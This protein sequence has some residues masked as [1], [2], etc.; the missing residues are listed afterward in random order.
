MRIHHR[1]EGPTD[2]P[3]L[4]LSS[5]L[6]TDL[7]LWSRNTPHWADSYRLLRYDHR[8]HGGSELPPGAFGVEDLGRDLLR[9][10]DRLGIERASFCGLSL[11]GA[12]GQWLAVNEPGRVDRLVLACTAARF[13]EPEGWLERAQTVRADGLGAIADAVVGRWFTPA[14]VEREPELVDVFR[15]R[16]LAMSAAAYAAACEALAEWD[17]RERVAAIRTPTLVIA[18]ADDPSRPPAD[19][20]LLADR[21]PDARLVILQRAAHLANVEQPDAFAA[22]VS[23]HLALQEAA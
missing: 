20:E 11:G 3:I 14:F 7:G 10:F 17:Y 4:V 5:S 19:A 22:A 15:Q 13:G 21:I 16:L 23:E 18:G 6:G 12:V 9:L 8:G 1:L 2:A